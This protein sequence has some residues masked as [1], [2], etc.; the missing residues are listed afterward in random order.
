MT[1]GN[2]QVSIFQWFLILVFGLLLVVAVAA[3][4]F[5][6][7]VPAEGEHYTDFYIL[8]KDGI[9]A[10]YPERIHIGE[11]ETIIVGVH[12]HEYRDI[13]YLM[14]IYLLNQTTENN[15]VIINSM[16]PLD[17]FRVSLEHDQHE[18]LVYTFIVDKTGYNRLEFLLFDENAP[19]DQV[20]GKDRI[21]ANYRDL[22]LSIQIE[23]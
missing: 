3:I 19:P 12:N 22:Y 5:V 18:E 14:E 9:A 21:N 2:E 15:E 16:E 13:T 7:L 1:D 23:E 6:I 11:P 4:V 20:M 8:G 17:R 10:D